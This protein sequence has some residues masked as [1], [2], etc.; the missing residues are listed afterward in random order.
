MPSLFYKKPH[1]TGKTRDEVFKEAQRKYQKKY[2][3]KNK[4][5]IL[6]YFHKYYQKHKMQYIEYCKNRRLRKKLKSGD[7]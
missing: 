1:H 6:E 4:E 5:K 2:Y 3:E 7:E